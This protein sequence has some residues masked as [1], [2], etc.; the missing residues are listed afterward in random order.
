MKRV[1]FFS[2]FF[3]IN[4]LIKGE[5]KKGFSE[6]AEECFLSRDSL[7]FQEKEEILL[8]GNSD[9]YNY[10]P[11]HVLDIVKLINETKNFDL[12][13]LKLSNG[14]YSYEEKSAGVY[15]RFSFVRQE[16]GLVAVYGDGFYEPPNWFFYGLGKIFGVN[17]PIHA[18]GCMVVK[19]E[20]KDSLVI[21]NFSAH[22][23]TD[24]ALANC[25]AKHIARKY[26]RKKIIS[27]LV[28]V[29]KQ[30]LNMKSRD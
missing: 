7:T 24:S 21:N 28:E 14:I 16:Q 29:L 1:I 23:K 27:S 9:N 4:F 10:I 19:Y 6:R 18:A 5:E 22:L 3:I 8:I 25:F 20:Q 12:E 17:F 11:S 30:S 26:F 2:L 13:V 15:G